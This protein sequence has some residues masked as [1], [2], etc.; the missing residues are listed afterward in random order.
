MKQ[1]EFSVC[2][3]AERDDAVAS[4]SKPTQQME[5]QARH[6]AKYEHVKTLGHACR[7]KLNNCLESSRTNFF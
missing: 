7:T 6:L 5:I 3:A 2:K 4:L 1:N